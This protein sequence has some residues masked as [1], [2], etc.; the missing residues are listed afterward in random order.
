MTPSTTKELLTQN[1][2]KKVCWDSN[3]EKNDW[4]NMTGIT[5]FD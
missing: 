4:H 2:T 3:I 1:K 5:D